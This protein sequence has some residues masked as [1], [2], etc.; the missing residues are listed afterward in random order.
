MGYLH[1]KIIERRINSI[2]GDSFTRLYDFAAFA[3]RVNPDKYWG[4]LREAYQ[5]SDNLYAIYPLNVLL[6]QYPLGDPSKMMT[7]EELNHFNSLKERIR[8]YRG[9]SLEEYKSGIYGFSWTLS[10]KKARF[11]AKQYVRNLF[12]FGRGKVVCQEI[13]KDDCLAYLQA[14]DEDEI[15]L[16]PKRFDIQTIEDFNVKLSEMLK[17]IDR[18]KTYE[19]ILIGI[20]PRERLEM[21]NGKIKYD[22]IDGKDI[23]PEMIKGVEEQMALEEE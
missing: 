1:P 7:K 18:P 10:R 15:I 3:E 21:I 9:M 8:V 5:N 19:E 14:R 20:S 13:S 6:F 12:K 2:F 16:R 4:F 11:F 22:L 23:G 17:V